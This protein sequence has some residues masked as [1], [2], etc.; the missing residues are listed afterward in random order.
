MGV[1]SLVQVAQRVEDL[2]RAVEF[3]GSVLGLRLIARFEAQCLAFFDLGS[4]RLLLGPNHY[5]SSLFLEV[6]DID[7]AVGALS[8]A[9]ARFEGQPRLMHTDES[10]LF[11]PVGTQEWMAFVWDSEG[12]LLGLVERRQSTG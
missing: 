11:G 9:G 1:R 12:N 6:D 2:D 10:G 8:A 5:S 3:Y 4:T 7:E